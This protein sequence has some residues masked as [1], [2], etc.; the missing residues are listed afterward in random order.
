MSKQINEIMDNGG[1]DDLSAPV[2]AARLDTS[3]GR[4][5]YDYFNAG[6]NFNSNARY[7]NEPVV[8]PLQGKHIMMYGAGAV[9]RP[10]FH[11]LQS[12]AAVPNM[13]LGRKLTNY[14]AATTFE[15]DWSNY[16]FEIWSANAFSYPGSGTFAQITKFPEIDISTLTISGSIDYVL[17]RDSD[18]TSGLFAG[19]DPVAGGVTIKFADSHVKFNQ[20]LGSI[21]EF[22][23]DGV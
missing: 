10:H 12:Q 11:W 20:T 16:D 2:I 7:P 17:F 15:T 21:G 3:S 5:D 8:L 18:N 22:D 19:A 9:A 4:L 1:W 23:K 6:V 13:L 14:N